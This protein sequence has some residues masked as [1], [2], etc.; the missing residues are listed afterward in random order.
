MV[1]EMQW[2]LETRAEVC[3]TVTSW[4][5]WSQVSPHRAKVIVCVLSV[6]PRETEGRAEIP[7][8]LT[9]NCRQ[10]DSREW[11]GSIFRRKEK[12]SGSSRLGGVKKRGH[13]TQQD[14]PG[15]RE[16]GP[17][18]TCGMWACSARSGSA[19]VWKASKKDT[20]PSL[21]SQEQVFLTRKPRLR[22]S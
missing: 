17:T 3:K 19:E 22:S 15:Q 16:A 8:A 13:G 10:K 20:Q 7:V 6:F 14:W 1:F 21:L 11:S 18:A 9:L 5:S 12:Q 4:I 2:P